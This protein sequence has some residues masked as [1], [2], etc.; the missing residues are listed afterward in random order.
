MDVSFLTASVRRITPDRPLPLAGFLVRPSTRDSVHSDLEANG[1]MFRANGRGYCMIQVDVLSAGRRLRKDI[2]KALEGVVEPDGLL[3]CASHTHFAPSIDR[4]IERLGPVDEGYYRWVRDQVVALVGDL[5]SQSGEPCRWAAGTTVYDGAV[6]RRKRCWV[7]TPRPPFLNRRTLTR[8]NR[9]GYRDRQVRVVGL[10]GEGDQSV[11]QALLWNFAC[12]PVCMP[13]LDRVSG[14]FVAE[15]RSRVRERV[16]KQIPVLF[17]AGFM[18][19]IRPDATDYS[20]SWCH[21]VGQMLHRI[22]EGP[23][24]RQFE[25]E[26]WNRWSDG[27][28]DAVF[29]AWPNYDEAGIVEPLSRRVAVPLGRLVEGETGSREFVVQCFGISPRYR[30]LGMSAEVLSGYDRVLSR[31]RKKGSQL[32]PLG[33]LDGVIGYLPTRKA[34]AEGGYEVEEC[35]E[36]YG[37]AGRFHPDVESTVEQ[38]VAQA[39][40][41]Q[42]CA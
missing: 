13:E 18:G 42:T 40:G 21:S 41:E 3:L 10:Y 24:F 11:P 39:C 35:R 31:W 25:I 23:R 9:W 16:G 36:A 5:R 12:H 22:L 1:V 17:L 28:A 29:R 15:V 19:D 6:S 14:D 32:V 33:Y 20:W 34:M 26:E 4:E 30:Y 2:V 8:P 27:I 37:L 38:L 7:P